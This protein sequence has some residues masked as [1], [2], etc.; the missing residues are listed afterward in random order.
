MNRLKDLREEKDLLQKDISKILN[1]HQ[2]T[3]SNYELETR[4]IS[5]DMLKKL[6]NFYNTSID[7]I[8]CET[9]ERKKYPDSI[10]KDKSK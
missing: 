1:I 9:D 3:Y 5:T 6:A 8:L 10:L 4:D 2:T 7:Y